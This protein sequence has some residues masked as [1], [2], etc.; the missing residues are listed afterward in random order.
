M[1]CSSPFK[2]RNEP[3]AS[4]SNRLEAGIARR[5]NVGNQDALEIHLEPAGNAPPL[6]ES[7]ATHKIDDSAERP[8]GKAVVA[9]TQQLLENQ[10]RTLEP[11]VGNVS[12]RSE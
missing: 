4:F 10:T 3:A 6:N 9:A 11:S 1:N 2:I 5:P 7:R 8:S 12:A